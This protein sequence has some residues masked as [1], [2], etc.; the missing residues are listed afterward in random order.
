MKYAGIIY[1][2]FAAAPGIS[3]SFFAQGCSLHCKGC[4]NPETWSFNGGRELTPKVL[5]SVLDGLV[6]NGVQRNFCI[7]GGEPLNC[8][9]KELT[10]ALIRI[11]KATY[12]NIK[13]YIWTGMKYESLKNLGD[14]T[15]N[16]IF[17]LAD[18]LVDGPYIEKLR[19]VT[20]KMRGSKN[21][22]IINLKTGE[23][24]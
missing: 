9:N 2:D 16:T 14:T 13:T 4:H 19:D 24:K 11:V 12:P 17:Q 7:M 18:V 6:A 5:V 22:R 1:N 20:L 15:I 10:L 23:I 3:L 8:Q 21:Q